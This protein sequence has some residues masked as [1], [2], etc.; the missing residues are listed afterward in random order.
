MNGNGWLRIGHLQWRA[1][2]G[3]QCHIWRNLARLT[4][5]LLRNETIVKC[6]LFQSNLH[7]PCILYRQV[8]WPHYPLSKYCVVLERIMH[9]TYS[10][11][12]ADAAA[13]VAFAWKKKKTSEGNSP[14]V[15]ILS[16]PVR[17]DTLINVKRRLGLRSVG[18]L[19]RRV[20][21]H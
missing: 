1:A 20:F 2:S 9:C 14:G 21:H 13:V 8:C 10:L 17:G 5:C 19:E 15:E 3:W 6:R 12:C 18:A 4:Y 11:T 16:I 7:I